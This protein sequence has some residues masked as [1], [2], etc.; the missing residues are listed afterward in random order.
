MLTNVVQAKQNSFDDLLT[1][2]TDLQAWFD[3]LKTSMDTLDKQQLIKTATEAMGEAM[4]YKIN[5]V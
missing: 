3:A 2:H 1:A 5:L 4:K